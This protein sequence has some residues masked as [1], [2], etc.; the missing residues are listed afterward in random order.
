MHP[1][2][3]LSKDAIQMLLGSPRGDYETL[4]PLIQKQKAG[5]ET[6]AMDLYSVFT[7]GYLFLQED[8]ILQPG[9]SAKAEVAGYHR[10]WWTW[11][12]AQEHLKNG[13]EPLPILTAIR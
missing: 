11:S 3:P 12:T 7:T 6:V 1:H 8:P 2:H 10:A 13:T 5:L 9:G 4:G